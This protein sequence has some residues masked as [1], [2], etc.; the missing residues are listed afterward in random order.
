MKIHLMRVSD[1]YWTCVVLDGRTVKHNFVVTTEMEP[2]M[3]HSI[4]PA[5]IASNRRK[6]TD[7]NE[8]ATA[9]VVGALRLFDNIQRSKIDT[10]R[11]YD[12]GAWTGVYEDLLREQ[13]NC[14]DFQSEIRVLKNE[15]QK[16]KK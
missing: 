12:V 15:L 16:V 11:V 2:T 5:F 13:K 10:Q 7:A 14:E 6:P 9:H 8:L 1:L 3:F 4:L